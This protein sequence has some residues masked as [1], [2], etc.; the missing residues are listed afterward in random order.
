MTLGQDQGGHVSANDL[1]SRRDCLALFTALP[2]APAVA[3]A[4]SRHEWKAVQAA[5]DDF[6]TDR[7]AP[8]VAV[9]ISYGDSEPAYPSAGTIAFD[10]RSAFEADSICRVYS[11]TKNV[12]RIASLLLVEDGKIE[13]DQPASSVLPEFARLRVAI[14]PAKGLDSRPAE[15]VMTIRRLITNTSGLGN[16]SPGSDSG[17]PLHEA[18][19]KRGITP[20]NFAAGLLRAE[21]GPQAT[22]MDDMVRRVAEFR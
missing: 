2:F 22:S 18:Y 8:G 12:T 14:D 7:N 19:R 10:S 1:T 21:Y 4:A 20:G 5:L 6:V 15:K 9:A 11:M 3:L 17:E 13:L 16:W